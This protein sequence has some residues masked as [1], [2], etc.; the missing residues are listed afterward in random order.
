MHNEVVEDL[1]RRVG[2]GTQVIIQE[3]PAGVSD[4]SH[5]SDADPLP[6]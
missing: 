1:G 5:T 6:Q 3:G 2:I 4:R